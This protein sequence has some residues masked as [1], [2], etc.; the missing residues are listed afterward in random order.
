[1]F[2]EKPIDYWQGMVTCPRKAFS[3]IT[4]D[5]C[6]RVFD[7]RMCGGC[8]VYKEYLCAKTLCREDAEEEERELAKFAREKR[9]VKR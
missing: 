2:S 4:L 3:H 9:K 7:I 8:D 5:T 1:M 6:S